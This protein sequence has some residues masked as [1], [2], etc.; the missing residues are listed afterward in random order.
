MRFLLPPPALRAMA[1]SINVLT[2]VLREFV[3]PA[4]VERLQ[5]HIAGFRSILQG[6]RVH[7]LHLQ[8]NIVLL[9]ERLLH[10]HRREQRLGL[11]VHDAHESLSA[12]LYA[13]NE[14]DLRD[15]VAAVVED[16]LMRAPGFHH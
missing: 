11:L 10:A 9:E 3:V 12:A 16:I 4:A 6:L 13:D 7:I 1:S 5:Q 15:A 2:L 8:R 14:Q